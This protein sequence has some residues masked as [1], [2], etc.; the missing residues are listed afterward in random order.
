[1]ACFNAR[2]APSVLIAEAGDAVDGRLRY[3]MDE[4]ACNVDFEGRG[5]IFAG[6]SGIFCRR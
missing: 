5:R 2:R 6:T 4:T 3:V 1:L